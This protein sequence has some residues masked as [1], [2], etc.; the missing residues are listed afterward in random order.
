MGEVWASRQVGREDFQKTFAVKVL[1]GGVQNENSKLMFLDE[2]KTAAV[3]QHPA[4][5]PTVDL[6]EHEGMLYIAMDLVQGPSLRSLLQKRAQRGEKLKPA[7]VAHIGARMANALDYAYN[8]AEANGQK[9][10]LIHR[11][12][13]PHNILIDTS[14]VVRLMDFGVAKT[15]I[16]DHLSKVGTVRGKP[17]YM[18]P[19]QV[20]G[21]KLTAQT[22]VFAL[23]TVMYESACLRRLFGRGEPTKSMSAVLKHQPASLESLIPGFPQEL[24]AIIFQALEKK[25]QNRQRDASELFEQLTGFLQTL[26]EATAVDRD[27]SEMIKECFGSNAFDLE[28]KIAELTR[29][30]I[31]DDPPLE[32]TRADRLS[33]NTPQSSRPKEEDAAFYEALATNIY[34]PGFREAD[35]S[36]NPVEAPFLP[37]GELGIPA[38]NSNRG[39]LALVLLLAAFALSFTLVFGV[40]RRMKRPEAAAKVEE[41]KP[42]S[43]K[44][45]TGNRPSKPPVRKVQKPEDPKPPEP[46]RPSP[47]IK[48]TKKK[49]VARSNSV[50]SKEPKKK[51]PKPTNKNEV[52]ALIKK[53]Q[54]KDPELAATY[55]TT[56]IESGTNP[57][58]L[59]SLKKKVLKALSEAR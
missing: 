53:L 17:S 57:Q 40:Q 50:P 23:G 3:L 13:S 22:D 14:G 42:V 54:A 21:E 32:K 34:W 27:L 44:A 9:L 46:V 12:I 1:R 2:A 8:R 25:P 20:T 58:R 41:T 26:P 30:E 33:D 15:T 28:T 39:K 48:P 51:T 52:Y 4:I 43:L 31:A 19:E 7:L 6:G 55:Q 56:L 24:E 45:K 29:E 18:A 36:Q 38:Q 59:E 47:A 37:Y 49:S 11:D 16:Q 35:T 5:V 10:R